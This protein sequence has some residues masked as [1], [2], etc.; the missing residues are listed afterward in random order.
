MKNQ[1]LIGLS[2]VNSNT[3]KL[4]LLVLSMI[5]FVLGAGAPATDGGIGG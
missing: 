2:K 4:V 5:L 3:V 1:M